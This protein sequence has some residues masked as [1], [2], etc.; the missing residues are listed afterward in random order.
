MQTPNNTST[1]TSVEIT[2][3]LGQE[4]RGILRCYAI[5]FSETRRRLVVILDIILSGNL[6]KNT[7]RSSTRLK[8]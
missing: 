8:Q 1:S 2:R 6:H 7:P 4:Q 3:P 5:H